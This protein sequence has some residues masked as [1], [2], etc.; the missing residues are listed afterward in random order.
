MYF[1]FKFK[2]LKVHRKINL[3]ILSESVHFVQQ[4]INVLFSDSCWRYDVSEE[5]GTTIIRLVTH[6]QC[7]RLHHATLQDRANLEKICC[8]CSF[9]KILVVVI[10]Y[11]AICV[12]FQVLLH[13]GSHDVGFGVFVVHTRSTRSPILVLRSNRIY[14][15]DLW[16][17]WPCIQ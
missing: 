15:V 9:S 14:L 2:F 17:Y 4:E 13:V 10:C 5:V 6:H 1:F 12:L 16:S 11:F 7:T 3:Q 8:N